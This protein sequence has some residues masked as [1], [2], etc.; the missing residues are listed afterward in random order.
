MDALLA[1]PVNQKFMAMIRSLNFSVIYENVAVEPEYRR[2][3]KARE[4]VNRLQGLVNSVSSLADGAPG[5]LARGIRGLTIE[6]IDAR[7]GLAFWMQHPALSPSRPTSFAQLKEEINSLLDSL[8]SRFTPR[9]KTLDEQK[10]GFDVD[11]TPS[12]R[13]RASS[14][15]DDE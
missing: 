15:F 14:G 11:R 10:Y 3:E 1:D 9:V 8:A 2:R 6:E 13:P 4:Q 5:R 12:P 7:P